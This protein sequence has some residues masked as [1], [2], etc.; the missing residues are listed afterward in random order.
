MA[1]IFHNKKLFAARHYAKYPE[2]VKANF[3]NN[4]SVLSSASTLQGD[5]SLH[6]YPIITKDGA[7]IAKTPVT[8]LRGTSLICSPS[9]SW[10]LHRSL[11]YFQRNISMTSVSAK[12]P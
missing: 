9:K 3:C 5:P 8:L 10:L 2:F 4:F 11:T 1:A 12:R 7:E 6:A